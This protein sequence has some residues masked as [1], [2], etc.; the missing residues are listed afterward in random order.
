MA[1]RRFAAIAQLVERI[2][3]KDEVSS[4]NLDSSSSLKHLGVQRL[5]GVL[6]CAKEQ[7]SLIF[8]T[9]VDFLR[10]MKYTIFIVPTG[11]K[12]P[13]STRTISSNR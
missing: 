4:S 9:R 12:K 5:Q 3:G 6:F 11:F 2:L 10:Q 1:L 7:V 8:T 13:F